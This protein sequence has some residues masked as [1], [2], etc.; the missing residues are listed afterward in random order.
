[1]AIK[2]VDKA[3]IRANNLSSRILNEIELHTSLSHPKII[4][5]LKIFEDDRRIYIVLELSR[6]GNMYKYLRGRIKRGSRLS[7][8][9]AASYLH[10]ILQGLQYL[11]NN[12][13]MHR[14]LKLSNLLLS[15]DF[16]AVKICDFGLAADIRNEETGE[17]IEHRTLCGTPNYIAPEVRLDKLFLSFICCPLLFYSWLYLLATTY[18]PWL[19]FP[20]PP[21]IHV[22]PLLSMH[23]LPDRIITG[24]QWISGL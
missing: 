20:A 15:A 4:K 2:C 6:G 23:R 13:I 1:V 18:L 16:K 14:D 11:H 7:E 24:L 3:F 21:F 19:A 10:Q 5:L 9:E 8:S 17:E 12:G 22:H